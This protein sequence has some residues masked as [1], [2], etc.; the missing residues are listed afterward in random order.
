MNAE[1]ASTCALAASGT[2]R[3]PRLESADGP[4]GQSWASSWLR[5]TVLVES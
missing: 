4:A 2:W 1:A 5:V 3:D